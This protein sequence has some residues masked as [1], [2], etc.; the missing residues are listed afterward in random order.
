MALMSLPRLAQFQKNC[1]ALFHRQLREHKEREHFR[2]STRVGIDLARNDQG[3]AAIEFAL[4]IPLLLMLVVASVTLFQL[5]T[6]S[7]TSEK[8]TFTVGDI[9]SRRTTVD[10]AFMLSTYQLFLRMTERAAPAVR[11]RVSSIVR[12]G[13]THAIAWSYA[14]APQ[15]ALTVSGLPTTKMPLLSNGDS[16]ILVET[17]VKP[18]SVSSFL[19]FVVSDYTNMEFVRPRFTAA[20]AKTD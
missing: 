8:S 1:K 3:V 5:F 16:L 7:K 10:N 19:P 6:A 11:F 13:S 18:P 9:V 12:T 17:T 15:T 20:I 4:I 2:D 14:V